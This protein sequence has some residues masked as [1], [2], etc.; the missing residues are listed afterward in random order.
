MSCAVMQA[1]VLLV[2]VPGQALLWLYSSLLPQRYP[3][4]NAGASA[5]AAV[6]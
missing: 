1:H 6:H 4:F 2:L 5:A 3:M